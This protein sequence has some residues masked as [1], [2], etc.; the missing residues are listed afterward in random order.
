LDFQSNPFGPFPESVALTKAADVILVP[1]TGHS[2]GHLSVVVRDEDKTIFL[3]GDTSYT[4]ALMLNRV[5]DG[6]GPDVAQSMVTMDRINELVEK[7][8][9]VYLPSHDPESEKR[10]KGRMAAKALQHV[11]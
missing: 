3:A 11:A 10:L 1:T 7:T 9:T 8:P 5:A 6:V 4:E 2:K